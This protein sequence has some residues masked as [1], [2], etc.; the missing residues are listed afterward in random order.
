MKQPFV[1]L[2]ELKSRIQKLQAK[3]GDGEVVIFFSNTEQYRNH[4]STYPFRQHS[5]FWYFTGINEAESVLVISKSSQIL[6]IQEKEPTKEIWTGIRNGID[7]TMEISGI[8]FVQLNTEFEKFLQKELGKLKKVFVS[9]ENDFNQHYLILQDFV[10]EQNIET[11]DTK[12]LIGDLRMIKSD[13]EI[14]QMKI[15]AQYNVKAHKHILENI[16]PKIKNGELSATEITLEYE[17]F[18]QYNKQGLTWAYYP[19]VASGNNACTLHYEKNSDDFNLSE[20]ILI[21]AGCEYNYYSSDVTRTYFVDGLA[22][23][24]RE[25]YD[26]VKRTCLTVYSELENNFSRYNLYENEQLIIKTLSQGLIDL[27]LLEG[28]LEQ[29]LE[30]KSY[31]KY[32]MHMGH[33]L[34]LD[35]HDNS[36]VRRKDDKEQF[37][38]F[39]PGNVFTV[40]PALY[41]NLNNESVPKQYRGIGIR[42]E[43]NVVINS[44]GQVEIITSELPFY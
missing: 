8:N 40:E 14:E 28:S 30:T 31:R 27:G 19:I 21:D 38:N 3:L 23:A 33:Y 36:Q 35:T 13:W 17:I 6:F 44:Q 22:T 16:L 42:L 25:I 15:A 10:D 5:D 9:C 43:D 20:Q 32:Y 34:G 18:Y 7:K 39:K 24:Q 2:N 11:E 41:F 12:Y 29:V 1:E 26:L 4:D 37:V